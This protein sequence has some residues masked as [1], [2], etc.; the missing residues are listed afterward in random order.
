MRNTATITINSHGFTVSDYNSEFYEKLKLYCAR[1][2]KTKMVSKV[3]H[4]RRIL[5]KENDRVFAS[6][7]SNR[8]EI[9]FHIN[10]YEEFKRH[11]Q[12]W[13]YNVS[14]FKE[15]RTPIP[16]GKDANFEFKFEGVQPREHQVEWLEYQLN[17]DQG[18]VTTKINTLQTG[19]G[20]SFCGI[21]NMVKLGK[22]TVIVIMPKYIN[23][24][25]VALNDFVKL[26][27]N[28]IMVVQGSGE[29]NGC[30]K[31]AE[32]GKLES[33]I[34]II[35]LPTFQ[36]YMSEYED[37]NGVM[38]HYNYT[39]DQFW[40]MIQPG[41]LIVDEG[42]ESIHALFKFDLYTH[43]KNKL[44]LSATLEADDQF[45]NDM[46][47]VIYPN[48]IRFRGGEYDKYIEAI[49]LM[50]GL[51]SNKKVKTKGFGGTYN[52]VKFE[53]SIMKDKQLL[54]TYLTLIN[55]VFS[56]FFIKVKEPEQ[57]CLIYCATVEMCLYV[58]DYLSTIHDTLIVRKYTQEDPKESLYESDVSV[59]T[60]KSAGTG[61][62][63]PGLRTCIMTIAIG[64]RQASD[65]ALGRLR[66]L[67]DY[68]DTIPTFVY[69]ACTGIEAHM[70]YHSKKLELFPV[71]TLSLREVNSGFSL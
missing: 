48:K 19:K 30:M 36:Y 6:A 63:I 56:F 54:K 21:Y 44:V 42:H 27:E 35:S 29:L 41:F 24:W 26:G 31:L 9:R 1:F 3:V 71:K 65:Q 14:R 38:T 52:H 11:M 8:R 32:E 34:I 70:K 7:L 53:Q 61:V 37:N 25:I 23:T 10:C 39:P 22:V 20:K 62:D 57:R 58:T 47:F 4:G 12:Q 60:L 40:A 49:A 66:R 16:E 45:I 43:V 55:K 18:E 46:Y 59:S 17:K 68:P 67:K 64:S 5:A 51:V 69:F 50:Y 13:G 15:V 28:D 2:V 33:R